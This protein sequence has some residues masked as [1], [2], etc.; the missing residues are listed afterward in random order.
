MSEKEVLEPSK[1]LDIYLTSP[2]AIRIKPPTTTI[3]MA[4]SFAPV[5]KF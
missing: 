4:I 2:C 1:P 3:K 5:N